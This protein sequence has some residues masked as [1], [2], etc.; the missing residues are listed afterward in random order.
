MG[1][2]VNLLLAATLAEG[3]SILQNAAIEP[4]IDNL[5]DYLISMGA[6]IQGRGTRTLIIQG[7]ESLT[8]GKGETIE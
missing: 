4:E 5:V 8:P 3:E 7:V 6:K 1:A 2:T